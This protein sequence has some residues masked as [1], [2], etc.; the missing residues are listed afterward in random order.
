MDFHSARGEKKK[1]REKLAI[2]KKNFCFDEMRKTR[3]KL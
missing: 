1:K 3:R 2:K